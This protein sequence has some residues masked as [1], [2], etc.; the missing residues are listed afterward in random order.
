MIQDYKAIKITPTRELPPF[1]ET[2]DEI[3]RYFDKFKH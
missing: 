3:I 2:T 1:S